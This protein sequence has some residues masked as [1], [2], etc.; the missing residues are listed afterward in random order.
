[1][2]VLILSLC[3]K[4]IDLNFCDLYFERKHWNHIS[5]LT[6]TSLKSSTLTKLKINLET[7]TEC[8]FLL[9]GNFESL[10]TLILH[11]ELIYHP[12]RHLDNTVC[13]RFQSSFL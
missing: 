4:L 1:M 10:T 2:F 6:D 13:I 9:N 3:K 12:I 11:V 8:L 5:H 7:F